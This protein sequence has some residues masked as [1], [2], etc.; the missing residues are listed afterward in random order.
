MTFTIN[1]PQM[2]AYIPYMD[3]MGMDYYSQ[4]MEKCS[5]APDDRFSSELLP[6]KLDWIRNASTKTWK[7]IRVETRSLLIS[8]EC[9]E[10]CTSNDPFPPGC[11]SSHR[12]ASDSAPGNPGGKHDLDINF[13]QWEIFRIQN[14]S[15][16]RKT[17]KNVQKMFGRIFS[18]DIP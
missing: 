5:K 8:V 4:Y 10:I 14:I 11:V 6:P 1:T 17:M 3:P 18:S 16:Y 7:N 12:S 15:R 9:T 2:L 13:N